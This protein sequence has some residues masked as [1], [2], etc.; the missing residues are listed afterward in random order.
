MPVGDGLGGTQCSIGNTMHERVPTRSYFLYV[1]E[2]GSGYTWIG[3][4]SW[5]FCRINSIKAGFVMSACLAFIGAQVPAQAGTLLQA[6]E[7]QVTNDANG[8]S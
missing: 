5:G 3:L 1:L 8:H 4:S 6:T 7:Y 2:A